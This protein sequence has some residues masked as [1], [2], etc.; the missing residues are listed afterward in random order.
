MSSKLGL[1]LMGLF[2]ITAMCFQAGCHT[3]QISKERQA[4]DGGDLDS[5]TLTEYWI[6]LESHEGDKGLCFELLTLKGLPVLLWLDSGHLWAQ[7]SFEDG[8][9]PT[10]LTAMK[11]LDFDAVELAS[12]GL[13]VLGLLDTGAVVF[14]SIR[15]E[16][17]VKMR[18]LQV[19]EV[20]D[21]DSWVDLVATDSPN[22]KKAF[23]ALVHGGEAES[24][25]L[26]IPFS[27][28]GEVGPHRRPKVKANAAR[29]GSDWISGGEGLV[30]VSFI[31]EE[32]AELWGAEF[33]GALYW[34]DYPLSTYY[35]KSAKLPFAP[36]AGGLGRLKGEEIIYFY[37]ESS[38]S[39]VDLWSTR[40]VLEVMDGEIL[41]VELM[42]SGER[43]G[44]V[45]LRGDGL[46]GAWLDFKGANEF[47]ESD[48]IADLQVDKRLIFPGVAGRA[49]DCVAGSGFTCGID[50]DGEG[51]RVVANH[52]NSGLRE[53]L[54]FGEGASEL[55]LDVDQY[56]LCG[57]AH[58]QT[59]RDAVLRSCQEE[60]TIPEEACD[61]I[62]REM[63]A[64]ERDPQ[65]MDLGAYNSFGLSLLEGGR[66]SFV[67]EGSWRLK[68]YREESMEMGC[69]G[70][71]EPFVKALE[72]YC[73]T[74][75]TLSENYC[76]LVLETLRSCRELEGLDYSCS[77]WEDSDNKC[78]PHE[79]AEEG[80]GGY[81]EIGFCL[82]EYGDAY[83]MPAAER[84][85]R[86]ESLEFLISFLG[87]DVCTEDIVITFFMLEGEWQIESIQSVIGGCS[88]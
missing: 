43:E 68:E 81:L 76:E 26:V 55:W 39:V 28:D 51:L 30:G 48:E 45:V 29:W 84:I 63:E 71:N 22:P 61:R 87:C 24:E 67:N 37:N 25:F 11:W 64:C 50:V 1:R 83:V 42:G 52:L 47:D 6:A 69:A 62:L 70:T 82:Y 7:L 20:E 16:Q 21:L 60:A 41:G 38:L 36:D 12:G 14:L 74:T 19:G 73:S 5:P 58:W 9:K 54:F 86:E 15:P 17:Q 10:R 53:A 59:L 57:D 4:L 44:F 56:P 77:N 27:E 46:W 3:A 72:S 88:A 40:Q 8:A 31:E 49:V 2:L 75:K 18:L 34:L 13:G 79:L 23:F 32:L 65:V 35:Q 66:L 80:I 33:S 85:H 78:T